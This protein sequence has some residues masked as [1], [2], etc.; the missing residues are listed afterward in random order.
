MRRWVALLT[1]VA[2]VFGIRW[3]PDIAEAYSGAYAVWA[4]S[5]GKFLSEN[6][7][8]TQA[9]YDDAVADMGNSG[10]IHL[11]PGS[12]PV[13]L[14]TLPDGVLLI[15]KTVDGYHIRG[16]PLKW[17]KRDGTQTFR[18]DSTGIVAVGRVVGDSLR[19]NLGLSV[20]GGQITKIL[21]GTFTHDFAN[22][23]AGTTLDET[24]TIT[25]LDVAGT[26]T[27]TVAPHGA[28]M[29]SGLGIAW[30]RVSA[31]NTLTIRVISTCSA[32][33]D[34]PSQSF[35]YVAIRQ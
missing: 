29:S 32:A 8:G 27:V 30:A 31:D 12:D 17:N 34:N 10:T 25:G 22:V 24:Q 21:R 20:G 35:S 13:T 11:G 4:S 23:S 18:A 2:L 5:V 1:A 7:P 6:Y 26:W 9:G 14:G 33:V 15:Q 28:N 19:G 16:V 3:G